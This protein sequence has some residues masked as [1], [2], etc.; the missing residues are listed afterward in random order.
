MEIPFFFHHVKT[1]THRLC[2]TLVII[3]NMPT[4]Q[5]LAHTPKVCSLKVWLRSD[6]WILSTPHLKGPVA[7]NMFGPHG[8]AFFPGRITCSQR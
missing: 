6:S 2:S 1:S 3:T 5:K 8:P 7:T 4:T